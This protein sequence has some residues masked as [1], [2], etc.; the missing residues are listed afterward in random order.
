MILIHEIE[1]KYEKF[2]FRLR[3]CRRCNVIFK[4]KARG[5]KICV[6]CNKNE[7]R[8]SICALKRKM[9]HAA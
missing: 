4:T 2:E 6:G 3:T 5:G 9:N 8:I 7:Q 1:Q